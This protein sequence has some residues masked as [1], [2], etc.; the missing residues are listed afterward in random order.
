MGLKLGTFRA[1]LRNWPQYDAIF[2]HCRQN[3]SNNRRFG[4]D[5]QKTDKLVN[6]NRA[7]PGGC[8]LGR[9]GYGQVERKAMIT[10]ALAISTIPIA[11][12]APSVWANSS[13]AKN[14]ANTITEYSNTATL[15]GSS[16]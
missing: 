5:S 15:V 14:G 3:H 9:P 13:Q 12:Q 1:L 8:F 10:P 16:I 7:T 2:P 4:R 6:Q 11:C